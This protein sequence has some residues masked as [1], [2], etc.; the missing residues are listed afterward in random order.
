MP[1]IFVAMAF[2]AW[3]VR[4]RG[5][6]WALEIVAFFSDQVIRYRYSF[7][8]LLP[9][10]RFRTISGASAGLRGSRSVAGKD[11]I[12]RFSN[13]CTLVR[14]GPSA[15]ITSA[16]GIAKQPCMVCVSPVM[17]MNVI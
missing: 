1:C 4:L 17:M 14:L 7:E 9:N 10:S 13:D 6:T 3:Y 16:L 11:S 15:A 12:S 5:M 2:G 8:K